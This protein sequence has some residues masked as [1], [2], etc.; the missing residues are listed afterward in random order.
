MAVRVSLT[1]DG[2]LV[3]TSQPMTAK[4]A[5]NHVQSVWAFRHGARHPATV[6]DGI[7]VADL[8][9]AAAQVIGC[10]LIDISRE[11]HARGWFSCRAGS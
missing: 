6:E 7:E 3:R 11:L 8:A 10:T 5:A 9:K 2:M 4:D 1:P